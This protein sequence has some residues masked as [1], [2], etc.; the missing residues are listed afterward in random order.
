MNITAIN[1]LAAWAE[2]RSTERARFARDLVPQLRDASK[3]PIL[4]LMDLR[5]EFESRDDF[6]F[7]TLARSVRWVQPFAVGAYLFPVA[8]TWWELRSV[9]SEFSNASG[10]PGD[11]SLISFW[12]GQVGEYSGRPLQSVGFLLVLVLGAIFLAQLAVDFLDTPDSAVPGELSRILFAIQY[13][14]AQTRVITPQDF[15]K[16]ISAAARELE[17]A[18]STITMT[19]NEASQMISEVSRTTAGLTEAT[20]MIG[21]VSVRLQDA[22]QPIVNL[23]STLRKADES[24]R[25]SA[26][27]MR[28]M[29][30]LIAGSVDHLSDVT[31]NSSQIGKISGE[32]ASAA[33]HLLDQV[34][35]AASVMR[36]TAQDFSAAVS[37]SAQISERLQKVLDLTDDRGDQILSIREIAEDI[38]DASLLMTRCVTEMKLASERFV[39]VNSQI[40]RTLRENLDG[41]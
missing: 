11:V 39:E 13:D 37:S 4:G 19:V 8:F 18:L 2:G 25:A 27:G 16:T 14:L 3:R 28:E 24:L 31:R 36:S 33:G 1:E 17:G 35:S 40:S 30:G 22:I 15:T 23:E 6:R 32:V 26:E 5:R 21:T 38:R 10:L 9:L 12:T 41:F 20:S 7:P 29:N 34:A